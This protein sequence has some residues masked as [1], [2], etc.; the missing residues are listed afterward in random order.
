[1]AESGCQVVA[2][3][4]ISTE[5]LVHCGWR[6]SKP[7]LTSQAYVYEVK[8]FASLPSSGFPPVAPASPRP[9]P[10]PS[11]AALSGAQAERVRLTG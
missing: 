9:D 11:L 2:L 1:M 10:A 3:Y 8:L 7:T 5:V 4:A 6:G